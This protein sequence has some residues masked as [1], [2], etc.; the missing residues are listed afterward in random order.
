MWEFVCLL[1]IVVL[2]LSVVPATYAVC[3]PVTDHASAV[4]PFSS[5]ETVLVPYAGVGLSTNPPTGP[6]F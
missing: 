1:G 2:V 3:V 4:F 5:R 6:F